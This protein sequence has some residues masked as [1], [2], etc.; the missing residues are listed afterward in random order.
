MAT[1]LMEASPGNQEPHLLHGLMVT[2]KACSPN[3]DIGV[4]PFCKVQLVLLQPM[5]GAFL[6][7]VYTRFTCKMWV[8]ILNVNEIC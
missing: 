8:C 6:L 3:I 4:G 7:L 2:V 5:S 1:A